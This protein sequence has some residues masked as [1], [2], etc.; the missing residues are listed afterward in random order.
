VHGAAGTLRHYLEYLSAELCHKLR[1]G[2]EFRGDGQYQL[3]EL[4]PQAIRQMQKLF[5]LAKAA[6]DSWNQQVVVQQITDQKTK[7][8][9][10]A[11]A[12]KAEQWQTNVAIHYNSWDNLQKADFEPVVKAFKEL[13]TG[14]TCP[15][16]GEYLH[17]S[18]E[19]ETPEAVRCE[20]GQINLNLKRK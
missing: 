16:C 20:C 9:A 12:S 13:L 8:I 3:G 11:E 4:L 1:A 5:S 2:V 10:L 15:A 18:P 7:F 19:R 14:F 6:A 17:V